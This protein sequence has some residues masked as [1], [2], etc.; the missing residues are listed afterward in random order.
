MKALAKI[1]LIT[2]TCALAL[3]TGGSLTAQTS[4]HDLY[5]LWVKRAAFGDGGSANVSRSV[6]DEHGN[7]Y[8][9]GSF[10]GTL[11]FSDNLC[12][13]VRYTSQLN[14]SQQHISNAFLVKFDP[15]GKYIWSVRVTD[16]SAVAA[17]KG[18]NY[19]T[20]LDYAGGKILFG[21]SC[22]SKYGDG[23]RLR[24]I[25]QYSSSY[26]GQTTVFTSV[27]HSNN[28]PK[29]KDDISTD[30][31]HMQTLQVIDAATGA[32]EAKIGDVD[33]N[34]FMFSTGTPDMYA[35]FVNNNPNQILCIHYGYGGIYGSASAQK[36]SI[37]STITIS[38]S[39]ITH[40]SRLYPGQ[41]SPGNSDGSRIRRHI[42]LPNAEQ[43]VVQL[44]QD[45]APDSRGIPSFYI[46]RYNT[47]FSTHHGSK[48]IH[49]RSIGASYA[50]LLSCD[51][52]SSSIYIAV[53]YG[54][55]L[56][57]NNTGPLTNS[58]TLHE[59]NSLFA[60]QSF[61]TKDQHNRVV[62]A[63]LNTSFAVTWAIQ[64]GN[65][66]SSATD[67]VY[68]TDIKT[69]GN[70]TY[71]TGR[72][73]GTSV[74]FGNGKVLTSTTRSSAT[75]ADDFDGFYAVYDNSSGA[76]VYAIKTGGSLE[77]SNNTLFLTNNAGKVLIGG[78]Y[79][80]PSFQVDPSGR[81]YPLASDVAKAQAFVAIYAPNVNSAPASYKSSYG[82]APASYGKA[83]H[84]AYECLRLGGLDLAKVQNSPLHSF[85]ADSDKNDDGFS[86]HT[87]A[88]GFL[89]LSNINHQ[90]NSGNGVFT[91]QVK[92]TTIQEKAKM[93]AWIDFNR[94]GVFDADEASTAVDVNAS[95]NQQTITLTW[96]DIRG[97]IRQGKTYMRIRLTTESTLDKNY[98]SGLFF[99][100]EVEDYAL[101][102]R[103]FEHT[104]KVTPSVARIGDILT[105]TI[106]I[107]N[108]S[109]A[110][111]TLTDLFD[112]IPRYTSFVSANQSPTSTSANVTV[113]GVQM[114]AVRWVPGTIGAGQTKAYEIK[115]S[116]TDAP[117]LT[118]PGDSLISNIAYAVLNGDSI[119]STGANCN[120]SAVE[121]IVLDAINDTV[122]TA[123][124]TPITVDV[125]ANDVFAKC[126]RGNVSVTLSSNAAFA[127]HGQA[128]VLAD[129]NIEYTPNTG[130]FF[131]DSL[132]YI[133]TGCPV[134]LRRDSAKVYIAA[135]QSESL[136]YFACNGASASMTMKP[137]TDV[138]Y[139]WFSQ[140]TG[141]S[142]LAGTPNETMT[143]NKNSDQTETFWVEARFGTVCF[144]R[145]KIE[146]HLLD[147]CGNPVIPPAGCATDGTVIWKED[148]GGANANDDRILQ[149][150]S[151]QGTTAYTFQNSDNVST[152]GHYCLLKYNNNDLGSLWHV[153]FSDH[154]VPDDRMRG[155]MFMADASNNPADILYQKKINGLCGVRMY[156]SLWA[157]NLMKQGQQDNAPAFRIEFID[158]ANIVVAT[159]TT[160]QVPQ[161]ADPTWYT[162]GFPF[163][164]EAGVDELTLRIYNTTGNSSTGNDFVIDDIELRL[165]A[166]K[167]NVSPSASEMTV[168]ESFGINLAG[169]YTD[170]GVFGTDLTAKWQH[171]A[172]GELNGTWTDVGAPVTTSGNATI[173]NTLN[174]PAVTEAQHEGYYRMIVAKPSL[175]NNPLCCASSKIIYVDVLKAS[176][177]PDIRVSVKP[178][179]GTVMLN[180]Y[181]DSLPYAYTVEWKPTSSFINTA[182][183]EINI[184]G[185]NVSSTHTATYTVQ[186]TVCGTQT[187]KAYIH[188]IDRYNRNR[189]ETIYICKDMPH[190]RYL[191]L[192]RIFG[193]RT[194]SGQWSYPN[195]G[196]YNITANNIANISSG[197]HAGAKLFD[198]LK[199]F[200]D[201]DNPTVISSG[202]YE[203]AG[204][205]KKFEI[206]YEEGGGGITKTIWIVVY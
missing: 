70:F 85:D 169:S 4:P 167:V 137:I 116:V 21:T 87:S 34:T 61:T 22:D 16:E 49:T 63:R 108:I 131:I 165:C 143:V 111:H 20:N 94:N 45:Y 103:L 119:P 198:V 124:S 15:D 134:N 76:C 88:D 144:P 89:D 29:N 102:F 57:W 166:P 202:E 50:P 128:I 153:D 149:S 91:I 181:I 115:V 96:G 176:N 180:A 130:E 80:S 186:S 136:N 25:T 47:D 54:H 68:C 1:Q 177:P 99:N 185:W 14:T 35:R 27:G 101:N 110:S 183:G 156:V 195:D 58:N 53:N 106:T 163:T 82:D 59:S 161:T 174:I 148:F 33:N 73:R 72:F 154:T 162:Y 77:D 18:G 24:R 118:T 126:N 51:G 151:L 75:E 114:Q 64:I 123:V 171:S 188:A 17:G 109:P 37:A 79:K 173:S 62:L 204:G 133:L 199:A 71:L 196:T 30:T 90:L 172:T 141:G 139:Y 194:A 48:I 28:D 32:L 164:V 132:R 150:E 160:P 93:I 200:N 100:G 2:M 97:K 138:T 13:P 112:P 78:S 41:Q 83:V 7:V 26:G 74:P 107:K 92:A 127:T 67:K 98:P 5:G 201:A 65:N 203:Y 69:M 182:T 42:T 11:N 10:N 56:F 6:I 140:Q 159:Y 142:P 158:K 175:I 135:L 178:A 104:K 146:L 66:N 193:L 184:S 60:G 197:K 40:S 145:H 9:A 129:K 46:H 179:A 117:Q 31:Y 155:Y 187:A 147:N 189:T 84:H 125:L 44:G 206:K 205:Q 95:P 36:R 152:Q 43:I 55:G 192:N 86:P 122:T 23:A 38:G 168:C 81:L 191:N 170:D 121:I 157:M 113:G 52:S 105:Y 19:P 12:T 8:V 120:L 190:S 3:L 39:T